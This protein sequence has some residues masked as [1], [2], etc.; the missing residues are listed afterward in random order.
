[1]IKQLAS[2]PKQVEAA[3]H[4]CEPHRIAFYLMEL[5]AVFHGLWNAGRENNDL[6]FIHDTD[7]E[8]THARMLLVETTAQVLKSGLNLL[9]IT[10]V[11]EM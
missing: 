5:A 4:H 9:S 2:W 11:E 10:A 8:L 1:M 6:K 7:D 3:T